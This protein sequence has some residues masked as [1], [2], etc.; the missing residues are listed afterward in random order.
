MPDI[1]VNVF[2]QKLKLSYKEEEKQRILKAVE[3]LNNNWNNHYS[4]FEEVSKNTAEV[5]YL[6]VDVYSFFSFHIPLT[7]E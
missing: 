5:Q 3:I 6:S 1:E 2:N 4:D 7:K